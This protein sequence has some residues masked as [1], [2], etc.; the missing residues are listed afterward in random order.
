MIIDQGGNLKFEVQFLFKV[1]QSVFQVV[2][3]KMRIYFYTFY[4]CRL[5]KYLILIMVIIMAIMVIIMVIIF[6]ITISYP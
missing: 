2:A 5:L 1:L 3:Y 6:F 4:K